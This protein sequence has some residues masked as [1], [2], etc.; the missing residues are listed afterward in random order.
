MRDSIRPVHFRLDGMWSSFNQSAP[1]V[2]LFVAVTLVAGCHGTPGLRKQ[3]YLESGNRYSANGRYKEAAIQYLNALRLDEEFGQAHYGLA[4]AYVHMSQFGAAYRELQRTITL[5][6]ANE[7]ARI[8]L[9]T[10]LLAGGHPDDAQTQANAV[11][12]ARP[13]NA[14]AHALLSAVAAKQGKKNQALSEIQRA[15]ELKPN[16]ASF[17]EVLALLQSDDPSKVDFVEDHLK[18][19]AALDPTSMKP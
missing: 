13:S 11:L 18:K 7:Q 8:D 10:L 5:Q 2:L 14:D 12:A 6:P 15:L 9:G 4:Q 17:H 19:A 3:K 1:F 16:R